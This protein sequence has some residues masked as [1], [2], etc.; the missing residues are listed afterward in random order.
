MNE[1]QTNHFRNLLAA[2]KQ[3]VLA[4]CDRLMRHMRE[5]DVN[6]PDLADQASREELFTA[7]VLTR[8]RA[9]QLIGKINTALER[10]TSD[11]YGDCENCGA[12]ISIQRLEIQPTATRCIDCQSLAELKERHQR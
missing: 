9:Q 8:G 5:Q 1:S 12:E 7:D 3:A 2:Q 11:Q 6:I 10:L 4:E